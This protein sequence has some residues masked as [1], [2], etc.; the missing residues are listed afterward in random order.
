M[1]ESTAIRYFRAVTESGSIKQAAA[2]LRIAPSAISRQVQAIEE[3]LSVKLFERGARGMTLTDAGHLLY[4]YAI[5]N[6]NQLD[7]IRVK[8]QEFDTLRRGQVKIAT[9]EGMLANFLSN[10]VIDLAN[11]YPGISIS[12]TVLGSRAVAETVGHNGVDLGLV[13]GRSPRRDLI[14]LARM[15]QSLCLIVSPRH[16]LAGRDHCSV[17]DLAGLRVV[18]PDISFGIRQEIDRACAGSRIGLEICNETNSLAFAQTL[19]ARTDLATFLPRDTAMP[20]LQAGLLVAV[21]LRDERLEATQVTLVQLAARN[22]SPS[23]RLVAD[24]LVGRMKA[25]KD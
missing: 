1:I 16:P 14:E 2:S 11:D 21:P 8:V 22:M 13:F 12:I 3:E 4:R 25:I 9:V 18:V 19:A 5:E 24:L 7:G 10:F 20:S 17:K 6:R 15:R 23:G